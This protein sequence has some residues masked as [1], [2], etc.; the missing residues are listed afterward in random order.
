MIGSRAM[1][2]PP[3]RS[4]SLGYF[5]SPKTVEYRLTPV[6]MAVLF[7]REVHEIPGGFCTDVSSLIGH[8]VRLEAPTTADQSTGWGVIESDEVPRMSPEERARLGRETA[9]GL[10]RQILNDRKRWMAAGNTGSSFDML[11]VCVGLNDPTRDRTAHI[12]TR[13][14]EL[15]HAK[16][17]AN[18][19]EHDLRLLRFLERLFERG[20]EDRFLPLRLRNYAYE[21]RWSVHGNLVEEVL[22]RVEGYNAAE[23]DILRRKKGTTVLDIR[24]SEYGGRDFIEFRDAL[25]RMGY[26]PA[27]VLREAYS[28]P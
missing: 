21:K 8:L 23:R 13:A 24:A 20:G 28:S 4:R 25:G 3:W 14:H 26:T 18:D 16:S 19:P 9:N 17:P 2:N 6:Q 22:A 27:R 15:L 1:W 10:R 11:R 5:T 7:G 12:D